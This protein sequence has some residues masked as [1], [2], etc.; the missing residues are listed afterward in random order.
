[1][2]RREASRLIESLFRD[3]GSALVRYAYR[4]TGDREAADDLIQESFMA[5]Y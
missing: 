1:M 5:L 4:L 2:D 3:W